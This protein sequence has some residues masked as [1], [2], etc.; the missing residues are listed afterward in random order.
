[1]YALVLAYVISL[2]ILFMLDIAQKI[3]QMLSMMSQ[4]LLFLEQD[5]GFAR[6]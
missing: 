3:E 4:D 6:K 1:M 5:E 2:H